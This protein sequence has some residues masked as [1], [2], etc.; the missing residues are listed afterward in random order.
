MA[1]PF[2]PSLA[3][4]RDKAASRA[5]GVLADFYAAG[6]PGDE[7]PASELRL[8]S[9]D[10][11]TTGLDAT[12]DQV[13]SIGFV[14]VDGD[15]IALGGAAHRVL[16]V[17]TEVGQSAVFHGITDDQI[18][19]G[20]PV[21]DAVADTLAA[22][23]GRAMLAHFAKIETEFLSLLCERLYGAPLV[24]PVVDTLVLQDRLVNRGFDD[25]SLAGQLRLWN[26]RTR[27]GLPVYKA[28]NALTDAVATA[29][30]YLAQVA[31]NAAVKAQTLKT[32]K[33]A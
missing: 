23:S 21:E 28:H 7:T 20:T 16:K 6:F 32:L 5:T 24:V 33:S 31:E 8:L 27:Y 26:A 25:E 12:R 22:L 29:E 30:L 10:F 9:L 1:W 15:T 2:S 11:E 4:R 17:T 3:K 19:S 18:A 13:L 14:P